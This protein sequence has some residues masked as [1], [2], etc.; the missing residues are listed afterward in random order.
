MINQ[1]KSDDVIFNFF[2][3]IC[4][5][6]NDVKVCG[7]ECE[8]RLAHHTQQRVVAQLMPGSG[9]CCKVKWNDESLNYYV[10]SF[11]EKVQIFHHAVACDF[12]CKVCF[13]KMGWTAFY[14]KRTTRVVLKYLL[15]K[16][17]RQLSNY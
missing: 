7:L 13:F 15:A 10:P 4:D 11:H 12:V 2:K 8:S 6:N 5:E 3:Q 14:S 17:L 16:D 1:I 9:T